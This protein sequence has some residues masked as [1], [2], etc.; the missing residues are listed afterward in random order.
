MNVE[1]THYPN[2]H[3][4]T[5]CREASFHH[6]THFRICDK[7]E[8]ISRH[9]MRAVSESEK[10]FVIALDTEPPDISRASYG[11]LLPCKNILGTEGW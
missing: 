1:Y 8:L 6:P 5:N 2:M 11:K 10:L 4:E 7:R 9:G 3:C